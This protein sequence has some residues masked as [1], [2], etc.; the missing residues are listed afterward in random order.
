MNKLV[1][2][3]VADSN[4]LIKGLQD[5]QKS[6]N[7]FVQAAGGAGSAIG[8]PLNQA[9]SA[10]TSIAKGGAGAAGVLAG[11]FVAAATAAVLMTTSAGQQIEAID[12]LSQKTGI[13]LQ[14]LQQWSVIM[15]ENGFQAET[16]SGGM[17]TLSRQMIEARNPASQAA[18]T[19]D[20]LG[21]SITALGS[22]E[23][24][25][26]AVADKFKDLP[27]GA[28]KARL[29]VTLFGKAGLDMIPMLNRG[30]AAFDASRAASERFGVVLS[31]QQVSAL[32]AVDD[33]SDRLGVSLQGLKL[34]LSAVFAG[35]VTTGIEAITNG[36][37]KLTS[38]TTNYATALEQIKANH[39]FLAN[40]AGPTL[41]GLAAAAA[42]SSMPPPVPPMPSGPPDA[43]VA[44]FALSSGQQ[45]EALGLKIRDQLIAK[46]KLLQ[47]EGHA[48][49][50][51]GKITTTMFQRETAERN[52]NFAM[53]VEEE[54]RVRM[55]NLEL[56][57]PP[58]SGPFVD[59]IKH[60]EAALQ[61]L[62]AIMPELTRDQ[63]ILHT[64]EQ[65][66]AGLKIVQD[67]TQAWIHRNDALDI[68]LD[69]SK[70]LD[71]AQSATFQSEAGLL[72]A[73]ELAR[74]RR[75]E[76][77]H[78]EAA[79]ERVRINE[80]IADETLKAA[81]IR[82]LDTNTDTK[83]RQAVQA[84]PSF[85]QQQMQAIV[86]SNAFSMG[87]MVSTWTGGIAQMAVHGGNLQAVWEQTQVALVQAALNAGVQQVV[88]AA[89]SASV[90]MGIITAGEA[91]KL[92]LKKA[93]NAAIVAGDTAAA[94]ATVGVWGGAAL[95]ISGFFAGT[96]V[97]F[98]AMVGTMVATV[99]AVGAF[100]SGVLSAIADALTATVFGIPWAGA[101][102]V[103]IA[104][105]AAALAA[106]GNLGFKDGG[107]G[108]F[109]T[110]TQA[111]LHGREAII[112]LN[113]RG[114]AF[115]RDAVGGGTGN[116]Q[117]IHTHVM[118][119]G[120][121]IARATARHLP[122]AWRSEGAPA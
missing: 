74:R 51:L 5:A 34:Q 114:A 102:L 98:E 47:S 66:A 40:L 106:T 63:A 42:A 50:A 77:I 100:V 61:N 90:E 97:G 83:R 105:I 113:S 112:P 54:D 52:A 20:E 91:A 26:R 94:T 21:I 99:T 9:M 39:P 29:A 33:A 84:F 18:N 89:L 101:I 49:E 69:R 80:T 78:D 79:R 60:K 86:A 14:S 36:I 53:M 4:P 37:A 120:R 23:S 87:S 117:I 93:T 48:Q 35:P 6:V 96:L 12:Q 19:F 85:F 56:S 111:T 108:D 121:E 95:A 68:A 76:L 82:N 13:A 41:S 58:D 44:D 62:L 81:A 10:F 107:I 24:T 57:K 45:Q 32:T 110:G 22:T 59:A 7:Q 103:G 64:M 115:M 122:S 43:H 55:L 11:G 72:G 65:D 118:L 116:G 28:D 30:A 104:L 46:Y 8:G 17:R 92:G 31:T 25:I 88:Q 71:S 27:D 15:A 67:S 3:L 70:A 75:I 38:I 119:N 109:G 73:S 1:L 16:L 2:E